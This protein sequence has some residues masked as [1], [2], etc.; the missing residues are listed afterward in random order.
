MR[1]LTLTGPGG[2]GKTRLA[3]CAAAEAV[4]RFDDGVFFVDLAAARD[5]EALL[6]AIAGA[7]GLDA[8]R[9]ELAPRRAGASGC[10]TSTCC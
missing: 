5:S 8:T 7:I 6:A 10:A 9:A 2:I 1:L 3:L 4:D